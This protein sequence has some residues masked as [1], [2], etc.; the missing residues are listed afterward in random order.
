[1]NESDLRD[2]LND[3]SSSKP[4]GNDNIRLRG[5][6][7]NFEKL[8]SILLKIPNEIFGTGIIPKGLNIA[9]I[10]PLYKNGDK[11]FSNYRLL[12]ILPVIAHI[13]ETFILN[14]MTSFCDKFSLINPSQ[15]G[16]LA[17]QI[18][19]CYLKIFLTILMGHLKIINLHPHCFYI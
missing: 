17:R 15:Y 16:V 14:T 1:M 12:S 19:P 18:L 8:K 9:K 3:M 6:R 11:D 13:M 4:P 7:C 10:R 2:I 5:L